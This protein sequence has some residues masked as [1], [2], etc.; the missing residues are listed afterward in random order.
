MP[1]KT[2]RR[3]AR[4][5]LQ[6]S[7]PGWIEK[8]RSAERSGNLVVAYDLAIQGLAEYPD[9]ADLRY[10]A[11]RVL[12]RSGS[13]Q[14]AAAL[15]AQFGFAGSGDHEVAALGA[16]ILKDQALATPSRRPAAL[17][18]A[19][20][21]YSRIFD[22]TRDHYHAVNAAT[23]YL[24]A[25]DDR[26]ARFFARHVLAATA[27]HTDLAPLD[28]YYRLASRAE[29]ALICRETT[30]AAAVLQDAARHLGDQ[31]DAAATTRK[32][33]RRVCGAIR[34]QP[35]LLDVLRPPAVLHYKAAACMRHPLGANRAQE[36]ATTIAAFLAVHR[37]RYAFGSLAAGGEILCAETCLRTGAELHIV[38][39]FK[40]DEFIAEMVRPAGSAW[41]R[42][43]ET[44]LAR[45]TSLTFSTMDAYQGD[46][47]LFTYADRLAM[48]ISLLR[49]QYLDTEAF[50]LELRHAGRAPDPAGYA[51][52]LETWR[53]HGRPAHVIAAKTQVS[54]RRPEPR[55]ARRAN[56]VPARFAR[57]ILFGDVKGFSRIPDNLIPIF[58]QRIMGAVAKVLR[59]YDRHVLYRN[60]W[61]DAIYVVIDNAIVAAECS[62][63]IQEAIAKARP[64]RYGLS[65]D[66]AMRL[67]VHFGPV[68]DGRDPIR[69]ELTFFGAHTTMT[70]RMEPVTAP[71]QVYVTEAMAAAIAM[72]S[73]VDLRV[74]YVGNVQMAKGFGAMRMYALG[75]LERFPAKRAAVR[76]KT[77]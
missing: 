75:R 22:L 16:R 60:S 31:F 7:L 1:R 42:R 35:D 43:F 34:I 52:N 9:N 5:G 26:R 66:L 11:T 67:A 8:I 41:V 14:Q 32:Q 15:Y 53:S 28:Q 4:R 10:L 13:T 68:Y 20:Q 48:G 38:L 27:R 77:R 12:A 63:A 59:H 61:G 29:A 44:C 54:K 50:H 39:P 51:A 25:G 33:L 37:V 23:L 49:G 62:L 6:R 40:A 30:L 58:Q 72:A 47:A 74:E 55:H 57:A 21:A 45:A 17:I 71:G 19:A 3:L 46:D 24:L 36:L 73:P 70:A 56:G 18:A 76:R 64:G 65:A 69:D 2:G